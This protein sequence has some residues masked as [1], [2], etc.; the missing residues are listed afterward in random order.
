MTYAE[1]RKINGADSYGHWIAGR[2]ER[3]DVIAGTQSN[4]VK[5]MNARRNPSV[6]NYDK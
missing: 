6:L 3:D 1:K 5:H 4:H 2:Q